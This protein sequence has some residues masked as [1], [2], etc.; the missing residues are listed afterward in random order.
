MPL[1]M[2][3]KKYD[4][5]KSFTG[6][7]LKTKYYQIINILKISSCRD[8]VFLWNLETAIQLRQTNCQPRWWRCL[9]WGGTIWQ[10]F[11]VSNSKADYSYNR[12][13]HISKAADYDK[14]E[15]DGKTPICD[16]FENFEDIT[17]EELILSAEFIKVESNRFL[18]KLNLFL[19]RGRG[20]IAILPASNR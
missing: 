10:L 12:L 14:E 8:E 4:G 11:T 15:W 3:A 17:D 16:K 7:I 5:S 20:E 18:Y 13:I 9:N 6:E 1:K 2:S 19:A